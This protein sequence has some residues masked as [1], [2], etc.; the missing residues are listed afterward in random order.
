MAHL[1]GTTVYVRLRDQTTLSEKKRQQLLLVASRRAS[2]YDAYWILRDIRTIPQE[3][4]ASL[5]TKIL[6]S[7][8][9]HLSLWALDELHGWTDD[10]VVAL[11]KHAKIL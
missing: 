11:R 3:I 5:R 7:K 8:N 6:S 4:Q 10:E 2:A 9:A 1:L